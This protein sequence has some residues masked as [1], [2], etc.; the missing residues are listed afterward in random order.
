MPLKFKCPNCE[1]PLSVNETMAGKRAPCPACKKVL[2]VPAAPA[3]AT[4]PAQTPAP[5]MGKPVAAK[6]VKAPAPTAPAPPPEDLEKLAADLLADEPKTGSQKQL[7][8]I[9]LDCP[10]CGEPVKM[11][12]ALAGKQGPCPECRR[13][14]KVPKL[15]DGKKDDW[16]SGPS[17]PAG[18]KQDDQPLEGAWGS[19][20]DRGH[21]HAESLEEAG[22]IPSQP[23]TVR[24]WISRGLVA[25]AVV[26]LLVGGTLFALSWLGGNKQEKTLAKAMSAVA[27][28]DAKLKGPEAAPI[29]VAAARYYLQLDRTGCVVPEKSD[30]GTRPQLVLARGKLSQSDSKANFELDALL[31]ELALAQLQ[32]GGDGTAVEERKKLG[33]PDVRH[34]V[35][36]TLQAIRSPTG[37]DLPEARIE[38]MRLLT[39]K[40]I[41]LKQQS[42]AEELA[43]LVGGGPSS[44]AAAGLE[45]LLADKPEPAEK[46][47]TQMLNFFPKAPAKPR[48]EEKQP[49][50]KT[51][52]P[53]LTPEIV[54]LTLALNKKLPPTEPGEEDIVAIGKAMAKSV[55]GE[56]HEARQLVSR[57]GSPLLRVEG[58]VAVA[59]TAKT[60]ADA[61][62]AAASALASAK[63]EASSQPIRGWILL[64]L[65]RL[66]IKHD[67]D[68]ADLKALAKR[69]HARDRLAGYAEL[70]RF[71]A[72]L[73]RTTSKAP[74]SLV[75]EV[76][77]GSISHG[78]ARVEFARHN[79][80]VDKGTL[81]D[82][83]KWDEDLRPYGYAGVAMGLQGK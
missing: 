38:G 14:I 3:P 33:W 30:N 49:P 65:I 20:T 15:P 61:K 27:G 72:Q 7:E 73:G 83:E 48:D 77:R 59:D 46:L 37:Q 45:F 44:P 40:L 78:V 31:I 5:T 64:R 50:P 70:L 24:Q 4:V 56:G 21:V 68:G 2:T 13:I 69:I 29:H 71:R 41:A 12:I 54:A 47:A 74:D 79:T 51:P 6:P 22:A 34:D 58:F 25:A 53:Q 39:R 60:D 36:Q 19:T 11:P 43:R 81:D 55:Q 26:V 80:L 76:E 67:L 63:G 10:M 35:V 18:A 57:L 23:V 16:R 32:M 28:K 8:T 66:G 17:K 1:K 82:V 42:I 75:D 52:S 62:E 9:A